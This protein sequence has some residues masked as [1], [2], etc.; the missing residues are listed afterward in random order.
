MRYRSESFWRYAWDVNTLA[1]NDSGFHV[2]VSVCLLS[3]FLTEL[4]QRDIS[5]SGWVI[6]LQLIWD[7]PEML[8]QWIQIIR[9]FLFVCQSVMCLVI[10]CV[11]WFHVSWHVMFH[12]VSCVM[13][14]HVSCRVM[15]H[16]ISYVMLCHMSC[17]VLC[18]VVSCVMLCLVSNVILCH[19]SFVL[20]HVMPCFVIFCHL[21]CHMSC[22]VIGLMSC[23]LM[24]HIESCVMF[25]VMSNVI[26]CHAWYHVMSYLLCFPIQ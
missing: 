4:I 9:N 10:S 2:C 17:C 15:C 14:C 8:V 1:R 19:M 26:S 3:Y 11:T 12:V 22:H 13:L 23:C 18:H 16:I 20:C 21:S 7:I 25:Q 24:C 6:F 5:R